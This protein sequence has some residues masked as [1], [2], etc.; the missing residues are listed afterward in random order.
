[1]A[2]KTIGD[3]IFVVQD[4][5]RILGGKIDQTNRHLGEIDKRLG[6]LETQAALSN[7]RLGDMDKKLANIELQSPRPRGGSPPTL[8]EVAAKD[9]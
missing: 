9:Q 1:M 4:A 8:R 2:D 6:R 5:T 3:L 7:T